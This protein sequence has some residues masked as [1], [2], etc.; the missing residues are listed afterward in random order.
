MPTS[1]TDATTPALTRISVPAGVPR[2]R[3][4]STRRDTEAM[5]GSASP[6]EA[7]RQDGGEILGAVD[8][9]RRVALERQP[10]ILRVHPDPVVLDADEALAAEFHLDGD[11][12]RARVDRVLDELLDDRRRALHH[13]A[14]GNLVGELR[15]AGG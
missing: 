1:R 12:M 5:L 9:A 11:A 3:V 2:A 6:A 15:G 8:L 14:G 13:L 7:Q 10:R 4:R